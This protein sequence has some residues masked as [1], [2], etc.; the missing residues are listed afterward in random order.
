M[1]SMKRIKMKPLALTVESQN[2]Y[3]LRAAVDEGEIDYIFTV[4]DDPL[5]VKR[6]DAFWLKADADP[7]S[8]LPVMEAIAAFH[9][10]CRDS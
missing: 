1:T 8:C 4:S 6:P 3:R 5:L 10:A 2:T 7:E 9:R